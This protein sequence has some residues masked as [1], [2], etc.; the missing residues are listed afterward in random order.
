MFPIRDHN[1]SG[2]T[3]VITW[4]LIAVNVLVFLGYAPLFD[5]PRALQAVFFRWAMIP[6][7]VS[8]G[9]M[10]HGIVT[11][12]FL[13]GGWL[14]LGM[15]MLFLWIF[16]DNI[17]DALG[18]VGFLGYYLAGGVA[19]ALAQYL[20]APMSTT[21]MLGASG[22][23]AAVMGGYLIM[24]PRARVDVLLIILFFIR[25]ISLPAWVILGIWFALQL[26][27]G[28]GAEPGAGGV[29]YWA[30][31]GGFAAGV[32]LILPVWLARGGSGRWR[33]HHGAPPH[34]RARYRVQRSTV[35]TVRRRRR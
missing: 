15:N 27:S 9:E 31:A 5:S 1:P 3:P 2:R 4:A 34:P 23:I 17:E 10:L 30:H 14:H 29:A 28:A 20:A 16:G 8:Q 18:H 33:R 24:Y 22:A 13:H 19:A 6:A 11:S 35:P 21:P 12:M 25:I 26:V 32:A 7:A